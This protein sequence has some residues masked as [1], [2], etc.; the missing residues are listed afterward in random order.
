MGMMMVDFMPRKAKDLSEKAVKALK[1]PGLHWVGG[2]PG[3]ALQ[4]DPPEGR[5][6]IL[7]FSFGGRRPDMGLGPYPEVSLADAREAATK[8]RAL[9][10]E[11]INPIE[12]R[13]AVK[14]AAALVAEP[15]MTFRQAA[16]RYIDA[17]S[18][19]W[20]NKK[21]RSQ[22]EATLETYVYPTIGGVPVRDV[23]LDHVRAI[24]EPI[25]A[26][27]TETASRVRGRMENIF[28]WAIAAGK[29][30]ESNPARWRGH[31]AKLLPAR[32]K[33]QKTQHHPALPYDEI[34]AFMKELRSASG[35]GARALEFAILTAGRSGE[36]RGARWSEFDL[37]KKL[38]TIPGE[39]MKEESDHRVP[40]SDAALELLEKL[41]R[42]GDS[43][44]VFWAPKG[45]EL[46]DA[47]LGAVIKR[48]NGSDSP[49]WVDEKKRP[50]VP[51]GFRSTFRDWAAEKTNIPN[52]VAEM[53]LSHAVGNKVEAAYRRGDLFEKRRQLAAQWAKFCATPAPRGGQVIDFRGRA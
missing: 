36:I 30:T 53:A 43:D 41:E 52:E 29:R 10:R 11:G 28:D 14:S 23:N 39:R 18:A 51:H 26:T 48:M 35:Q 31:L 42:L 38:W 22:W 1:A 7:R 24:L 8:A 9:V 17:H 50:V 6:W 15:L 13:K 33:V 45:G 44:L 37:R 49:R 19:G 12:H 46:S 34:G 4:V 47:T 3:L 32:S 21:H 5:S 2:V 25:W 20:K 27:K 40:L 16:E